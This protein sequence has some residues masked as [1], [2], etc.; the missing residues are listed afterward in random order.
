MPSAHPPALMRIRWSLRLAQPLPER[1]TRDIAGLP[2][3]FAGSCSPEYSGTA[4][5]VVRH[6][7]AGGTARH[8]T[9]R[10]GAA[11]L[12]SVR[13]GLGFMCTVSTAESIVSAVAAFRQHF[14]R[15]S[16]FGR[17]QP[18]GR[19]CFRRSGR[20]E[21]ARPRRSRMRSSGTASLQRK[22]APVRSRSTDGQFGQRC[23]FI[24]VQAYSQ[25]AAP[26]RLSMR[27]C[28][29]QRSAAVSDGPLSQCGA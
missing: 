16:A 25:H 2:G 10:H 15:L 13:E 6:G 11:L 1:P 23:G 20:R 24:H 28:C 27:Q 17:R 29:T 8:G 4:R 22:T 9:A 12:F 7:T 26:T 14:G 21:S 19:R 3:K 18:F 5:Q